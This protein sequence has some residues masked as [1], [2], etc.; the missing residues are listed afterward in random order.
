MHQSKK[1]ILIRQWD[2]KLSV[3]FSN[4]LEEEDSKE[5]ELVVKQIEDAKSNNSSRLR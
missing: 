5:N 2:K 4:Q 3:D 1:E